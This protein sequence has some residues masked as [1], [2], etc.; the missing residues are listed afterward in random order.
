M[1]NSLDIV[2]ENIESW[3]S[4]DLSMIRLSDN[5]RHKSPEGINESSD[6]FLNDC[7]QY[8]GMQM[9]QKE[10]V[11]SDDSACVRYKVKDKHGNDVHV[12][13]WFKVEDEKIRRVD[14][15]FCEIIG[16]GNQD[17][18]WLDRDSIIAQT[19]HPVQDREVQDH[20]SSMACF[21]RLHKEL[22]LR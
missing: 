22:Q 14:V 19:L 12:S 6:N 1:K 15:F 7:R 10:F 3:E 13:E 9:S 8:S 20:L 21:Q 5:F 4:K 18:I 2:K 17:I 16:L 11:S